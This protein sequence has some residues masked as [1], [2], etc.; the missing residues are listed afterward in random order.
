MTDFLKKYWFVFLLAIIFL[1]VTVFYG[2]ETSKNIVAGKKVNGQDIVY[3]LDQTN[4][5]A[6]ELYEKLY[7]KYGMNILFAKIQKTDRKSVV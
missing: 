7:D 4:V 6:D 1:G 3:S 2:Y 5:S